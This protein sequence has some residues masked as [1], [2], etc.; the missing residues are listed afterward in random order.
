MT[1]RTR[2]RMAL[3]SRSGGTSLELNCWSGNSCRRGVT[4]AQGVPPPS[5][6]SGQLILDAA[7]RMFGWDSWSP[8]TAGLWVGEKIPDTQVDLVRGRGDMGNL[9]W[10]GSQVISCRGVGKA[11]GC[12]ILKD[13]AP[14]G[15][16]R[17]MGQPSDLDL[18][19]QAHLSTCRPFFLYVAFHDPHRCGHAQP[20][21]GAFCEKFGNGESGMGRIPDWTPQTYNP[22]DVQVGG[23]LSTFPRTAFLLPLCKSGNLCPSGGFA[24]L[25]PRV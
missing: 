19:A 1:L 8:Q 22:K 7:P 21:Y 11:E 18:N 24:A 12:S 23:P 20:Q 9:R 13:E 15:R 2:R 14:Q 5:Q 6:T 10:H 25:A 17:V 3:S 4:G 16:S